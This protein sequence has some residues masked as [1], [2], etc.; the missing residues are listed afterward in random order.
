[1]RDLLDDWLMLL[2]LIDVFLTLL[3]A[4]ALRY[5]I[6][7][8]DEDA[9]SY[10]LIALLGAPPIFCVYLEFSAR[11][12]ARCLVGGT[13]RR[14]EG[15]SERWRSYLTR[16]KR[17][18]PPAHWDASIS[19]EAI[20]R[21]HSR[22][23][24]RPQVARSEVAAMDMTKVRA[25]AWLSSVRRKKAA[26]R[27]AAPSQEK[28][29]ASFSQK[30]Q[31]RGVGI[32]A[33]NAPQQRRRRNNSC[34][35]EIRFGSGSDRKSIAPT[36]RRAARSTAA[37]S[38]PLQHQRFRTSKD[39]DHMASKNEEL[40][41]LTSAMAQTRICR[42]LRGNNLI[43][44][45]QLP[46]PRLEPRAEQAP[47]LAPATLIDEAAALFMD[48]LDRSSGSTRNRAPSL[49]HAQRRAS[50]SESRSTRSDPRPQ[51]SHERLSCQ[52]ETDAYL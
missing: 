29:H 36:T 14:L 12:R 26:T 6:G 21:L 30:M 40:A 2:C 22:Q 7:S 37:A 49:P 1:M 41:S 35:Q 20:A 28:I 48:P 44:A 27:Q 42:P 5:D 19:A 15:I 18:G 33:A 31:P 23:R 9:L 16:N 45:A 47:V 52:T 24:E 11:C 38:T 10:I 34:A 32:A 4:I 13:F 51:A 46:A 3:S 39:L 17:D 50:G 8:I 43:S 25:C